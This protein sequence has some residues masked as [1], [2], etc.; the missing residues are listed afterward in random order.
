MLFGTG[1]KKHR[2]TYGILVD[3]GSASVGM[4]IAR[5]DPHKPTPQIFYSHR[6][7]IRIGEEPNTEERVRAMRHALFSASL[8][9]Q[10]EGMTELRKREP[11]MRIERTLLVSSAPWA[12]TITRLI[13]VEEDREFLISKERI[14]SI[15]KEAEKKDRKDAEEMGVLRDLETQ[16]VERAII[17]IA[18]NGYAVEN[19]YDKKAKELSLAHI[20]GLVP[21]DI[22]DAAREINDKMFPH[23]ALSVHTYAL[24]FYCVLRDLYPRTK[25]FLL[26]HISGEATEIAFIGKQ[27]L[28]E[29][30][31]VPHGRFTLL[32]EIAQKLHGLPE[33]MYEHLDLYRSGNATK[34]RTAAIAKILDD[35]TEEVNETLKKLSARYVIPKTVFL[36]TEPRLQGLYS[37]IFKHIR[38][39]DTNVREFDVVPLGSETSEDLADFVSDAEKDLFL[40]ILGRFFHKLHGCTEIEQ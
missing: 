17:D 39:D 35:Y 3:I 10:N 32:R 21:E 9:L 25:N 18:V 31:T 26:V 16:V 2:L 33:E 34:T 15:V 24:V 8:K 11:K 30:R 1:R 38:E 40:S 29:T 13:H 23:A 36:S 37:D 20:S 5:S 22:L 12:Y 4:G 7:K 27:V 6:E 14:E 28:F 19:P